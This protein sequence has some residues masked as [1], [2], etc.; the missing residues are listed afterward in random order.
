MIKKKN[1]KQNKRYEYTPSS[2]MYTAHGCMWIK[3][4]SGLFDLII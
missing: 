2:L 1:K 4:C 3:V